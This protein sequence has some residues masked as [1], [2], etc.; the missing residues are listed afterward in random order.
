MTWQRVLASLFVATLTLI[1][2]SVMHGALAAQAASPSS[3]S[4]TKGAKENKKVKTNSNTAKVE[5]K[6]DPKADAKTDA[7]NTTGSGAAKKT[8][9]KDNK[10]SKTTKGQNHK[11]PIKIAKTVEVLPERPPAGTPAR[12]VTSIKYDDKAI[13]GPTIAVSVSDN[14]GVKRYEIPS[15]GKTRKRIYFDLKPAKLDAKIPSN[16][17]LRDPLV[18]QVRVAQY[19]QDTVRVVLTLSSEEEPS[20]RIS[21]KPFLIEFISTDG[22][23]GKDGKDSKTVKTDA[24]ADK[25]DE[26]VVEK[27]DD[28]KEDNKTTENKTDGKTAE[29][30][31]T[32][33]KSLDKVLDK[34]IDKLDQK[35]TKTETKTSDKAADKKDVKKDEKKDDKKDDKKTVLNDDDIPEP[36]AADV[37]EIKKRLGN[38]GAPGG[39]SLS[40]QFGLHVKRIV[41]DAGH[42]GKDSGAVGP[43]GVMEKDVTLALAKAVREKLKEELPDVE[44][45]LTRDVDTTL[46]L[47]DRTKIANDSEADLFISIHCNAHPKR[48]V[49]GVQTY[50]LNITHDQYAARLAAR[51]NAA[52]GEHN[53]SDL[54][55]IL[56]DLA[57][58]SN[59]DDS[60]RLGEEVQK[61][62]VQ[63][64]KKDWD[65]VIDLGLNHA[66]FYVLVGTRMPSILIETSFISNQTEEQRLNSVEY[67]QALADGIVSGIRA[68]VEQR[69]AFFQMR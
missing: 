51:E 58:K 33:P 66:L 39:A 35:D 60:V 46:A 4:A 31:A 68:F 15:D 9:A 13:D 44:V 61:S 52:D 25:K 26:K 64:L 7:K 48:K 16:M 49:R 43:T 3:S 29:N 34:A 19:D 17:A 36:T 18:A 55:F 37:K 11:A 2:P 12:T 42:G 5:P 54:E 14:V 59:V 45:V 20:L 56:A 28:K 22:K 21:K 23:D 6:V 67:Q 57:M 69:H 8:P 65:D 1:S 32:E 53:I 38:N 41:I 27:K 62:I 24:A 10:D 40:S 50:Y 63:T 30:K 47:S